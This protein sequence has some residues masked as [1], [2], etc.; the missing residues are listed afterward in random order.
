MR[1]TK[2]W[3]A[4][5]LAMFVTVSSVYTVGAA[6]SG[7]PSVPANGTTNTAATSSTKK[8]TLFHTN[9]THSRIEATAEG[10]GFAKMSAL[11]KNYKESTPNSLILDAGDTFHGQPIANLVRGESIVD[12]MNA[13]GYN[14][15]AA[16]NH[17]FNYGYQRLIELSKR[18]KF[19]VLSANTKKNDGSRILEPYVIKEV[20]GV[21]LGI[22]GLTTP[23]TAYKTHPNNVEGLTFTDPAKEAKKIVSELKGKVDAIIALTHLGI[24]ESS[25]E[26]SKKVAAAVP[27]IDVIIDGHSHTTLNT[28]LLVGN[29]LIAQTGE[30]LK[31]LG[32]VDLTFENGKLTG[33]TSSLITKKTADEDKTPGDQAVLDII[34]NVKKEQDKVLQEI[35][36]SSKVD[37][38]G[39][40]EVVRK[41]E[42]NLGNLIADAMLSET[43]ADVSI[44]NGGGIRASIK[45]GSITKGQI[46]TVLPFG[47][48]IQ[49]KKVKGSDIKAALELGLSAYPES[50]GGFPHVGGMTVS[51]DPSQPKGSRVTSIH[52]KGYPIDLGASY[53][54]ATNDFMAAGGD[55]YTMFKAYPLENDFASLE[56]ALITYMRK[57]GAVEA[58][59]EG[60]IN[61]KAVQTTPTPSQE[62]APGAASN[63]YVVKPGDSLWKISRSYQT[64]WQI[65]QQL[66]KFKNPNLIYPGQEIKVP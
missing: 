13:V 38:V 42:S 58:K 50:L 49:T 23:E 63:I 9:D 48:Y 36:G 56:E 26:T 47:N 16:G 40:R 52:V 60:R 53:L 3:M 41:G 32:R 51:F 35:V 4:T 20:D 28:G 39:E 62:L 14:A 19:P 29:V 54:L 37:L 43:G 44:T 5:T 66:N 1:K 61:A 46:V 6:E 27:E 55:Q 31:N 11:I 24:D 8:I 21:K 34:A 7:T 10:I 64:T 25:I 15:M 12:I 2:L 30:Y 57:S 65:L 45:A 59:V 33:K 22:F 17:D 18:A